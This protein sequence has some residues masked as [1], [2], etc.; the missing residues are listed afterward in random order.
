MHGK[1]EGE[2]MA[3]MKY[4][5][6]QSL[7]FFIMIL[8]MF[9]FSASFLVMPVVSQ[10]SMEGKSTM[11]MFN[12][13]WFWTTGLGS[14]ILFVLINQRRKKLPGAEKNVESAK[15]GIIR[16][17]SNGW[18]KAADW[19]FLGSFIGLIICIIMSSQSYAMFVFVFFT[20]FTFMM[21]C[22]FNGKNFK[23]IAGMIDEK[24]R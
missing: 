20:V 16:F 2:E 9:L 4:K 23:C 14:V 10:R 13:I 1:I 15:P 11:L 22:V 12:G 18:A 21:H 5:T 19:T 7:L 6:I 8:F 17:C 3:D 24:R